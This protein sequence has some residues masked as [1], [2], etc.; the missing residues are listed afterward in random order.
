MLRST[1]KQMFDLLAESAGRCSL[2][3][4]MF[5]R[6]RVLSEKNGNIVIPVSYLS[7]KHL[8]GSERTELGCLSMAI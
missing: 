3:T 4:R 7:V 5:G 2:C 1:K 8:V 6:T